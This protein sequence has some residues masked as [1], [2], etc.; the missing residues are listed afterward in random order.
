MHII[1]LQENLKHALNITERIIGRNLTLPILN[2][3]LFSTEK[4]KLKISSTNL[5]IGI[6]H[7]TIGKIESKGSI[8]VPARL[9]GDFVNNLPS[10]KLELKVK[11]DNLELKCENFKANIKGLKADDFPIIPKIT[12]KPLVKIKRG[13]LKNGFSQVVNMVALSESRPGISGVFMK[14][15]K[16]SVKLVSTDTFRLAEKTIKLTPSDFLLKTNSE[17]A[18]I[19]PQRTIQEVIRI[20]GETNAKTE[21]ETEDVKVVF[22]GNQILFDLG[23]TQI[24]SRLIEDQ[25]PNYRQIIPATLTTKAIVNRQEL[26]NNIKIASLFSGRVNDVKVITQPK[27]NI[28]EVWSKDADIGEHKSQ[29]KAEIEGKETEVAFNYR[30]ILDA[31]NNIFS[32]KV[33]LG[34]NDSSSSRAATIR[35]VGD[36][37]YIYVLMPIR[38]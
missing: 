25:Y 32:D 23:S 28:L 6:N 26:I 21:E 37:S 36:A 12:D 16:N 2:N 31:L 7:W 11:N 20:L 22:S 8:T 5:E 30:Y 9:I 17:R 1:C 18:V 34:L 29:L 38:A 4:N 24:I 33:V 27:K 14:I 13:L 10:K 3:L 19:V 15:D 35:P